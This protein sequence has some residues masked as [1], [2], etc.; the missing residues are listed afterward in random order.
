MQYRKL[1]RTGL[2]VSEIC[3]GTMTFGIQT[4]EPEAFKIMDA[5][6]SAGVNF[7]DT[8]DGYPLG[9]GWELSGTTETFIGN[10]LSR[11]RRE[12]FV[13]A[14]KC[15]GT[16]GPGLND[17]GLSR[18]HIMDAIDGSLRRL[19]TDHI[20]LYQL[21]RPDDLTPLDETLGTMNDLVRMGKVRYIG[22]SNFFAWQMALMLG[23]S[24]V[25]GWDR[26][27]C[28]QPR[29]NMLFREPETE[30]IP[31][32][33]DQGIGIIAYNPLAGGFL[34]G[35]YRKGQDLE[36]GTRFTLR[37][38][39][40]NYQRRYWQ[41]AQFDVVE[42]LNDF[43][44]PRNKPLAQVAASWVINRPGITSAIV[45]ASRVEQILETLPAADLT[46]EPDEQAICDDAWYKLPR[47]S[48]PT[49]ATR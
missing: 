34:T 14:T 29:Y 6:A 31:L 11:Q 37:N 23:M 48:D 46:L 21:H 13:I 43:F 7:I 12:D 22:V 44:A 15:N 9:G 28:D 26:I 27:V 41:D 36:E 42:E 2:Q 39:G 30:I 1:G 17:R 35:K 49:V 45:G 38:A 33:Q 19:Q 24:A 18:R 32:C 3:L 5:A 4:P 47:S 20:D 8:A 40:T 10:W 25:N 16:T